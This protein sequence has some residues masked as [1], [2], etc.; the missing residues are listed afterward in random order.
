MTIAQVGPGLWGRCCRDRVHSALPLT[1]KPARFPFPK[2]IHFFRDG[3]PTCRARARG[4]DG[5]Y[6]SPLEGAGFEL[7]VPRITDDGFETPRS[8]AYAPLL[9]RGKVMRNLNPAHRPGIFLRL[10]ARTFGSASNI[11]ER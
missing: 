4:T 7:L 10:A 6:D 1:G 8:R 5:L 2:R 3:G 11:I 9:H